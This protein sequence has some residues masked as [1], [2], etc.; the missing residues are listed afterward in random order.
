MRKTVLFSIV[1]GVVLSCAAA[2][3][4]NAQDTGSY[5]GKQSFGFSTSWSGD[6]SHILIGDSEKRR[7]WTLGAEYSRI[8]V[9]SPHVRLDYEGSIL[10]LYQETDPTVTG[11]MFTF[12]GQTFLTPQAPERVIYVTSQPVGIAIT[13]KNTTAP[14]YAQFAKE[15]TYAAAFSPLGARVNALPRWRVQPTLSLD[16]GFVVS[17]QDIPIDDS[18]Q[19]N[20]LF[21]FGPGVELFADHQTSWRLE[22]LYRHMSNGGLG[23]EN[24]GVDQGVVRVTLSVHR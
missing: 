7:V 17:R 2:R 8:I 3:A 20:F 12:N 1:G 13:G 22:Y 15:D 19:F 23:N 5:G 14:I 10:P 11:T 4:S 18:S 9:R 16:L 6:S 21:S 24:P